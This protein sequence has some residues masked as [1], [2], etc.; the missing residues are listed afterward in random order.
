MM[1]SVV[2]VFEKEAIPLLGKGSENWGT[3]LESVGGAI[4]FARRLPVVP[5]MGTRRIYG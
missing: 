5:P 1:V 2:S 3:R 4:E